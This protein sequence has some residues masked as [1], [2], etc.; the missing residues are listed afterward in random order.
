MSH[1]FI[2]PSGATYFHNGD[3]SGNISLAD[4]DSMPFEDLKALYLESL[5][6]QAIDEAEKEPS[7]GGPNCLCKPFTNWKESGGPRMLDQPGD[8]VDMISGWQKH[9][10]CLLH[11]PDSCRSEEGITVGLVDAWIVIS[12]VLAP[13][14][15]TTEK[16]QG[17]LQDFF[18]DRDFAVIRTA[19]K[20][21]S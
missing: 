14:D 16:V 7:Y 8:T 2:G 5:R 15:L 20:E 10:Q 11:A 13:R 6:V 12:R 17:A 21:D 4:S 1:T 19:L 3:F 18:E 9:E